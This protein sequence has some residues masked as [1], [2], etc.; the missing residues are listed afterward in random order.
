MVARDLSISS[1]FRSRTVTF[2]PPTARAWAMPG[3]MT[4][5]RW[6][7][8]SSMR[9]RRLYLAV[10][11]PRAGAPALIWPQ[12]V[13]TARSAIV[14]S[15]VSPLRGGITQAQPAARAPPNPVPPPR[16][17]PPPQPP[18]RVPPA[19][20]VV[21]GHPVLDGDDRVALQPVLPQPRH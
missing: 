20:P 2:R 15:S 4:P 13:A 7:S 6:P 16:R 1:W 5:P 17:P 11:S 14:V 10:R 18:R 8:S 21:L 3:P 19:R 12:P 9:R